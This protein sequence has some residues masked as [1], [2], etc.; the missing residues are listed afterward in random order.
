MSQSS[1]SSSRKFTCDKCNKNFAN[2]RNL[3]THINS[4]HLKVKFSCEFCDYQ[5]T[6]KGHLKT[7]I[8]TVHLK[9]K[10]FQ[11]DECDQSFGYSSAL[12]THV[13]SVHKKIRF[14]CSFDGCDKSFLSKSQ[15]SKHLKLHEGQVN[16]CDLCGKTFTTKQHLNNHE[17]QV[18]SDSRP[19][20]CSIDEC[21][22]SFK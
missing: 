2:K 10:P 14:H 18:H 5:S 11:C 15:F 6:E 19:F 17:K 4:I 1:S 7:H 3:Q 13:D 12:K 22:K 8:N 20:V 21:T 9:L 16:L